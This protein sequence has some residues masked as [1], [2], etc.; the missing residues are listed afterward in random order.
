[1]EP[2]FSSAASATTVTLVL[3][4]QIQAA[5]AVLPAAHRAAPQEQEI[6][7]SKD[8]A[9]LRL[10][11]WAFTKGF[12]LA[13][14]SAKPKR[15]VFYCTYYKKT[16]KNSC[17]TAEADCQQVQTQTQARRCQF[18]LYISKTQQADD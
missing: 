15:V 8:A 3:A 9:L 10:Q 5:T 4:A 13:T 12:V 1:M 2:I 17:K 18:L 16:I 11:N 6:V 7:E 14:E